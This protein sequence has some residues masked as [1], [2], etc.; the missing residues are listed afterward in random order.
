M[1]RCFAVA[2]LSS[3]LCSSAV[4]AISVNGGGFAYTQNFNS[5]ASVGAAPWIND[6]TLAGWSLFTSTLATPATYRAEIGN[7]DVGSFTSYGA[8]ASNE[9]AL[10]AIG[11]S[12]SYFGS[13]ASG[14]IAG[15]IAVAFTNDA[16]TALNSFTLNFKGEQWRHAV[17][18]TPAQ[19]M[20]LEYGFGPTFAAVNSWTVPGGNF[21]WTSPL[22]GVGTG[23][24]D[25]NSAGAVP[26]RGGT[27][28]VSW[29]AGQTLWVRW[30]ERNDVGAD[31][32]LGIDDLTF[33]VTAVP[34]P[35]QAVLLFAGGLAVLAV[36]RRRRH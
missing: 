1:I 15:Y 5:L 20:V 7:Q 32:G 31:Q 2:A 13:P 10:G 6:S 21:D 30:I 16:G 35:S 24:V 17:P 36:A 12:N 3:V 28:S 14:A 4:A 11:D 27:A 9:R 26:N 18:L 25:G 23:G 29:A 22:F 19:T 33:S 8:N 34:E